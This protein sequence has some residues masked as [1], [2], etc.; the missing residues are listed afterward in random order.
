MRTELKYT[1][2]AFPEAL[3][4]L[5]KEEYVTARH[6]EL[7]DKVKVAINEGEFNTELLQVLPYYPKLLEYIITRD[8]LPQKVLHDLMWEA[9]YVGLNA[10]TTDYASPLAKS[11]EM[12]LLPQA[13][14]SCKLLLWSKTNHV[15]PRYPLNLYLNTIFNDYYWAS[16]YY[17]RKPTDHYFARYY[18]YAI[19]H[20]DISPAA[21]LFL[22]MVN[23]TKPTQ[24]LISFLASEPSLAIQ[25]AILLRDSLGESELGDLLA[26]ATSKPNWAYNILASIPNLPK[27]IEVNA[28]RALQY[29]P[30]WMLQYIHKEGLVEG[31]ITEARKLLKA[32]LSESDHPLADDIRKGVIDTLIS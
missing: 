16:Y 9:P 8:V 26:E 25:A 32:S 2:K 29:S 22:A 24:E 7:Y 23:N 11:I 5:L 1:I 12:T 18:K 20:K 31:D 17:A 27:E 6:R 13:E 19:Q 28:K 15:T 10:V 4:H 30:P 3:Y 21:Q 14:F